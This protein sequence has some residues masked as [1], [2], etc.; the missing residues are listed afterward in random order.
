M[1]IL[2]TVLERVIG[3]FVSYGFEVL[4][5]L[6]V[7]FLGFKLSQWAANLTLRFLE[8][9]QF[10]L[11]V[12]RFM[13]G[14]VKGLILGFAVIV[15]LG[16]FGITI[17]PI[18]A[19]IGAL[20]FG[21]TFALQGVLSNLGSGLSLLLFRPFKIGD[22]IEVAG[23]SGVVEEVKLGSTILT[24]EDGERITVPNRHIIGEVVR[25]SFGY[26]VVD[27]AVGISY[28]DD[29]EQAVAILRKALEPFPE[30]ATAPP[31]IIGIRE[32]ADSCIT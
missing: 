11:T 5:A 26:R 31:A 7:L 27:A 25:N 8:K 14:T 13:S 15:A 20:A 9:K 1:Q 24:N 19:A 21:G 29:P 18:V 22:T 23:V 17:A 12:A 30:V 3:F 4:G 28:D 10:D 6:L 16:K 32:F 2:Q